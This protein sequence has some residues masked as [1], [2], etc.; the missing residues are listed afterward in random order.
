MMKICA[1]CTSKNRDEAI[2]CA[3]CKRPLRSIPTQKEYS[4]RDALPW[5][6]GVL[7]VMGLGSIIVSY[8]SEPASVPVQTHTS[9]PSGMPAS[10]VP[11]RTEEPLTLRACVQGQTKIRRGPGTKYETIG[12]LSSGTCLTILG[13]NPDASWVSIVSEDHQTGWVATSL[14]NDTGDLSKVSIRD[15]TAP[16]N[17]S[18]PTLTS[19]EIAYG[20]RAYLTEIAAT[21][22]PKSPLSRYVVP[23]F[24]T[25]NRLGDQVSC[26]VEKAYCDYLPAAD[27][28][29]TVCTDRPHPDHTFTLVA[30][31]K[32]W[33]EY[34]GQC[35]IVEGYLK[36]DNGGLKIEASRR[37]Q[38]SSCD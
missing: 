15:D 2:F 30:S 25:V 33:S 24:E 3:R 38:V 18:R 22:V 8:R 4:L 27:G 31:G 10:V 1:Y 20:A 23:C 26:R 7:I 12:G 5:L 16:V 37:S 14:L 35:I 29:P 9:I 11:T 19:A 6:W 17:S 32:D 36:I 13:R 28:S 34:D 21:L